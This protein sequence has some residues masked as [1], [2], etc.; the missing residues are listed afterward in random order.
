MSIYYKHVPDGT[1]TVGFSY[2]D[3]CVYWYKSEAV[4]KWF[5]DTLGKILY[6]KFLG[7]AYWFMSISISQ[8]KDHSI[9]V[10]Q[11]IY[12]TSI[13]AKYLDNAI[14]KTSTEFI[15]PICHLI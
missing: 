10:D 7:Y 9:S 1:M 5:V 8:M 11:A 13:V 12:Y 3:D 2:A 6:V 4:V 15:R 14:F